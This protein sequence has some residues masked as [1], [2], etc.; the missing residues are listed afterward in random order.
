MDRIRSGLILAAA[1]TALSAT[2]AK[3]DQWCGSSHHDDALVECGYATA[4]DCESAVG[5]GGVCFVDPDVVLNAPKS[6]R[7]PSYIS[8]KT[9]ARS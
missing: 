1:L 9:S 4:A 6:K 3:A 7:V 5:K 8:T 2:A